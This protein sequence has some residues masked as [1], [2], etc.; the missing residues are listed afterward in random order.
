VR[1]VGV[2]CCRTPGHSGALV[3]DDGVL[4]PE[5]EVW[6][7]AVWR[8]PPRSWSGGLT[9]RTYSGCSGPWIGQPLPSGSEKRGRNGPGVVLDLGQVNIT[10]AE[11]RVRLIDV[12]DVELDSFEAARLGVGITRGQGDRA[13]GAGRHQLHKAVILIDLHIL[14]DAKPTWST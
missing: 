4:T 3:D 6:H 10:I 2:E 11:E 14:L 12:L 7:P 9:H 1:C 8:P 5:I 13:R